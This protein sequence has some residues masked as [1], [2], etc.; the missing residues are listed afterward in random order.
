[1]RI[2]A[3]LLILAVPMSVACTHS[4]KKDADKNTTGSF[5]LKDTGSPH[6]SSFNLDSAISAIPDESTV[7]I[8]HASPGG[9][10]IA[11][12][13]ETQVR[14]P[15]RGVV[16]NLKIYDI[17]EN[18]LLFD[19]SIVH[20]SRDNKEID[21]EPASDK[22]Q[23]DL[24]ALAEKRIKELGLLKLDSNPLFAQKTVELIKRYD[25]YYTNEGSHRRDSI[26]WNDRTYEFEVG[27]SKAPVTMSN[28][29]RA[30][31]NPDN[32]LSINGKVVFGEGRQPASADCPSTLG[33]HMIYSVRGKLVFI[34]KNLSTKVSMHEQRGYTV[35]VWDMSKINAPTNA[36]AMAEADKQ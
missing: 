36:A 19:K 33:L 17:S 20:T 3:S 9:K 8:T 14:S 6:P 13:E 22:V 2:L 30:L 11:V 34:L 23:S 26:F 35:P 10:F 32:K 4:A 21:L 15:E 18:I 12:Y 31:N 7:D 16:G 24:H 25:G 5:E 28:S 27:D 1:M 29:C